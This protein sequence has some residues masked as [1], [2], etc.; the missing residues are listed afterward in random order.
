MPLMPSMP[1]LPSMPHS[2]PCQHYLCCST[3][4]CAVHAWLAGAAQDTGIYAMKDQQWQWWMIVM[5]PRPNKGNGN[6]YDGKS[7]KNTC[8]LLWKIAISTHPNAL[9]PNINTLPSGKHKPITWEWN[10][11]TD[12]R[13]NVHVEDTGQCDQDCTYNR[14]KAHIE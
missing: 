12:N 5:V 10:Y 7:E 8:F 1:L 14:T 6:I 11:S 9:Y 4:S 3:I 13:R 2:H